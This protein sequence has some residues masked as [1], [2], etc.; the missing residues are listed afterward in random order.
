[1]EDHP[2]PVRLEAGGQDP[3]EARHSL[4]RLYNGDEWRAATTDSDFSYRYAAIGDGG[5]TLRTSRM[6]GR[7]AGGIGDSDDVVVQWIVGGAGRLDVGRASIVMAE[8]LPV[9]FPVGRPFAFDYA[10]FDQRLVHLDRGV[11][12]RVGAE[13]GLIGPLV[14]DPEHRPAEAAIR[15]WRAAVAASARALRSERVEPLLWDELTRATA[16][17]LLD[18]SPPESAALPPELLAPRN[19]RV[20]I[21]VEYVHAYCAEPIGPTEI[22]EAAGLSV[23]GVQS[24]FQRVLGMR[25]I[26]YLRLVRLDRARQELAASPP[27]ATTVAAVAQR[28][29]FGNAGRFSAAYAERFGEPPSTTLLR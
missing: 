20:R 7:L 26:A 23:R 19:T 18:L 12:D 21:A 8:H 28:W 11:V 5:M 9:L 16:S 25:P 17:A 24:A 14:F 2:R 4:A 22:A 1:M 13:R 3:D 27:R 15:R 6:S 29:G 10:D